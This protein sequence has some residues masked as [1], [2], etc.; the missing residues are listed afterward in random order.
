M[1]CFRN[2]D[3]VDDEAYLV[4]VDLYVASRQIYWLYA[5]IMVQICKEFEFVSWSFS[6]VHTARQAYISCQGAGALIYN[7]QIGSHRPRDDGVSGA[8]LF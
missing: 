8:A 2:V 4:S 1:I 7:T 3:D 5:V 6:L